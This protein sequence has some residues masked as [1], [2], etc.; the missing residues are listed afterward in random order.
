MLKL[1]AL[2][3]TIEILEM[4]IAAQHGKQNSWNKQDFAFLEYNYDGCN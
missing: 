1:T 3:K 4:K 2:Q